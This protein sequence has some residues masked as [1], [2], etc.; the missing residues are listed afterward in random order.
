MEPN[1]INGI[2]VFLLGGIIGWM[3]LSIFNGK[4]S[5]YWWEKYKIPFNPFFGL[6]SLIILLTYQY[7]LEYPILIQFIF[8]SLILTF[9]EW[10]GFYILRKMN[11]RFPCY[12]N[13]KRIALLYSIYWGLFGVIISQIF[14]KES[15]NLLSFILFLILIV[16]FLLFRDGF[17]GKIVLN[18]N[19]KDKQN[20]C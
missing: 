2:W 5:G 7:V 4:M 18:P 13:G 9:F 16:F 1:F 6:G 8:Y 12:Y 20:I 11:I 10:I 19:T 14:I 15:I 3:I 17:D